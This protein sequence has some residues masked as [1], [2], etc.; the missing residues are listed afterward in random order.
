MKSILITLATLLM[1]STTA[2]AD[3]SKIGSVQLGA[4]STTSDLTNKSDTNMYFG[5]DAFIPL[6]FNEDVHLGIGFDV[7]S[8]GG[9]TT[10][11]SNGSY[12]SGLQLKAA[13][14]LESFIKW[15]ANI[16]A[17]LGYGVTRL[18]TTNKWGAQYALSGEFQLYKNLGI[19]YKYKVIDSGFNNVGN[20]KTHIT[21]LKYAW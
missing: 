11:N 1:L 7:I 2:I 19:G 4:N 8:L 6:A 9:A 21:Y 17:E 14:S 20:I 16:K 18:D 10:N 3:E 13:Y 15:K 5:A 12:S